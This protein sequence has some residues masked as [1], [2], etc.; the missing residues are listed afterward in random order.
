MCIRDSSRSSV[1]V[2]IKPLPDYEERLS[3]IETRPTGSDVTCEAIIENADIEHVENLNQVI[4]DL[5]DL[6]SV[7]RGTKI[8]WIYLDS[9][10]AAGRLQ[11]RIHHSRVTRSYNSMPIVTFLGSVEC[12]QDSGDMVAQAARAG[13]FATKAFVEGAYRIYAEDPLK[14]DLYRRIINAYL[15]ARPDN[16]FIE[17]RAASLALVMEVI[18]HVSPALLGLPRSGDILSKSMARTLRKEFE[19][20]IDTIV[21]DVE[22]GAKIKKDKLGDFN[23]PTFAFLIGR[24]CSKIG[25]T[26]TERD[27]ELV[28]A[29]RN[30]LVHEGQFYFAAADSY[31]KK[32]LQPLHSQIAEYFFLVNFLDRMILQMFGYSGYYI[33]WRNPGKPCKEIV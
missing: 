10:D 5:C 13:L 30:K 11:T 29:S 25:L 16:R 32:K 8:N 22:A 20:V 14:K 9:Y 7:T 17:A 12:C 4:S 31:D 23:H 27:L 3:A 33:N 1:R 28:K 19:K 18:R 26:V 6:L 24:I 21:K 2:A 15:D